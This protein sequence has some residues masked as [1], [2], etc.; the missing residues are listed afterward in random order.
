M[1]TK[2]NAS[3]RSTLT[4]GA[5]LLLTAAL[6]GCGVGLPTSP[7][8][9]S[10]EA[11]IHSDGRV[12]G[13]MRGDFNPNGELAEG[14]AVEGGGGG[15]AGEIQPAGEIEV[16]TPGHSP[17]NSSWGQSHKKIKN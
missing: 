5:L 16:P 6:T 14:D 2:Y 10:T 8:I 4:L 3:L 13:A 7:D 15:D 17:G 11:G 12:A 1:K 9:Q